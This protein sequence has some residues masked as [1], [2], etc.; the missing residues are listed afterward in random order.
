MN[1]RILARLIDEAGT[2]YQFQ[3]HRTLKEFISINLKHMPYLL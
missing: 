3:L 1:N 2:E